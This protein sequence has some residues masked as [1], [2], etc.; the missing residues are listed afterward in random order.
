[1]LIGVERVQFALLHDDRDD[2]SGHG[3]TFRGQLKKPYDAWDAS[4]VK[5]RFGALNAIRMPAAC[6]ED[7]AGTIDLVNTFARVLS[8]ISGQRL[9]D[10]VARLF[11]VSHAGD[12]TDV[13]EYKRDF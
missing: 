6:A 8:C 2:P 10:K 4:D 13:H 11:V 5:E 3:E 12:M 1:M 7:A 9:P